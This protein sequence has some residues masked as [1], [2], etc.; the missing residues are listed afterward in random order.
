VP[1]PLAAMP[2]G[3]DVGTFVHRVLERTDFA[4]PALT[5]EL[6]DH[7]AALHARWSIDVGDPALLADGL[8][9][10]LTTPLGPLAD[11]AALR[12]VTRADRVDELWFELPLAGGDRP[13]GDVR[14]D[15]ISRL[16]RDHLA[17][18]DPLAGYAERLAAAV[19][20]VDLRGYLAGSIDL[21]LRLQAPAAPP[22]F[23]VVDYKTN[24]LGR[25]GRPL[26]TDDYRPDVLA[27]A[28]QRGHYPLQA[29]LY[30][31]ALH[32]YLRWRLPGYT[33]ERNLGGVAYLFLRGMVGPAAPRVTGQPCGVFSW[34]P[35]AGLVE[36]LSDALDQGM[37]PDPAG[38]VA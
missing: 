20:W 2:G 15:V 5:G 3:V 10:A 16:L 4:A 1:V 19:G 21:V 37:A 28:M 18:T 29:L 26:T 8:A 9:A 35:P 34:L 38:V 33:P 12:D 36:A 32:R 27:E 22:R 30:T 31:V 24:W 25:E 7:I 6:S 17:P 11:D 23:L 13:V 14:V